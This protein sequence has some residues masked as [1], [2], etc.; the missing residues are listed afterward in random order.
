MYFNTLQ[1]LPL[2]SARFVD[3]LHSFALL[4][5]NG[6]LPT[7]STYCYHETSVM[8]IE[9]IGHI[10]SNNCQISPPNQYHCVYQT[11]GIN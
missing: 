9:K 11:G 10:M 3:I 1:L 5:V 8:L 2:D 7:M 6:S 4:I